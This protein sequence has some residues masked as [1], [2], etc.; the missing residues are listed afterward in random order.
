MKHFLLFLIGLPLLS[1]TT[2]KSTSDFIGRW[3]GDD[4]SEVGFIT[5]DSEGYAEFEIYGEIIG[6]KSFYMEEDEASMT[7]EIN[8]E[9]N[10]IEVDFIIKFK[11]DD[12]EFRMLGIAKFIDDNSFHFAMDEEERPSVFTDEN[13][14]VLNRVD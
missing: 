3:E 7:Y 6:G 14:I 11:E 2:S 4:G 5:F 12:E 10:P 9:V 1:L 13:S 8:A